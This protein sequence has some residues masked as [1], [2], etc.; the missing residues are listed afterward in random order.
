MR[1]ISDPGVVHQKPAGNGNKHL[2]F[3][4]KALDFIVKDEDV[5]EHTDAGLE[6]DF[7]GQIDGGRDA[8]LV[9]KDQ[10]ELDAQQEFQNEKEIVAKLH[11]YAFVRFLM[12]ADR[13]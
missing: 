10:K 2:V 3:E 5:H 9:Q 4:Q 11:P 1:E 7:R 12:G 13:V 8:L 6:Q